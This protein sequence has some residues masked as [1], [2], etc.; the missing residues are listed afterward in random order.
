M[1][2]SFSPI[3]VFSAGWRIYTVIALLVVLATVLMWVTQQV[4]HTLLQKRG[5]RI[6]FVLFYVLLVIS[7]ATALFVI[8]QFIV[9][10]AKASLGFHI[11]AYICL[12]ILWIAYAVGGQ[13]HPLAIREKNTS[14]TLSIFNIVF[15]N[16]TIC[17]LI[18]FIGFTIITMFLSS[19]L[20]WRQY[21]R[22]REEFSSRLPIATFYTN[23][24]LDI[25]NGKYL[26]N[27]SWAYDNLR[28]L[29]K[30]NDLYLRLSS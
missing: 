3:D 28:F 1:F 20:G 13:I 30:T 2:L 22:D 21:M 6:V 24:E 25:S 17:F 10:P 16:S 9:G 15:P 14:R 12:M 7:V 27:N 29:F 23:E 26:Q 4:V 5:T 11:L 18:I 19:H 8:V